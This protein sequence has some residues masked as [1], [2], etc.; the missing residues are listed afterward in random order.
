MIIRAIAFW[1]FAGLTALST[2][3][4]V[5]TRNVVHAALALAASLLGAAALFILFG[6]E[7]I[8]L[9][10]ILI[11]VGAVVILFLFGIML[12]ST[13]PGK[14]VVDNDQRGVALLVS[15]GVFVVLATGILAAYGSRPLHLTVAFSTTALGSSVF[16]KWIFPFEAVSVLLLAALVGAIVLAR[17]D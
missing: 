15:A 8:G 3:F 1:V 13:T 5:A 9:A 16:T 4:V 6:A 17:K 7:F 2:I 11:Y 10:Q 12:T 14:P